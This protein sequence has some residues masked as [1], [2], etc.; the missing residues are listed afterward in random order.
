ML[1]KLLA[2]W[3]AVCF[4]ALGFASSAEAAYQPTPQTRYAP[5]NTVFAIAVTPTR[6]YIGGQFLRLTPLAGGKVISRQGIAAFDRA[7][8]DLITSFHPTF[9]SGVVRSIAVSADESTVLV[10]GAFTTVNGVSHPRLAAVS[11]A[12][13]TLIP[14]WDTT[15]NGAVRDIKVVGSS[16]YLGGAFGNVGGLARLGLTK[17]DV[18]TGTVDRTWNPGTAGG[19]P[20]A[21]TLSE[22]NLVV[23]GAFTTL[24]GAP[25][26]F[27]GSVTLDTGA[28][29]SW[30]PAS[31][32]STCTVIDVASDAATNSVLAGMAGP[33]GKAVSYDA[34]TGALRWSDSS[35]GNVQAITTDGVDVYIGGHFGPNPTNELYAANIGTGTIDPGFEPSFPGNTFPGIWALEA[36]PEALYVGGGFVG[37]NGTTQSKYAVFPLI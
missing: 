23:G 36:A 1:K 31:R 4:L 8:G 15:A 13:G 22:G 16:A 21:L 12:D 11:A 7:T 19:R 3:V 2:T 37:V 25:R 10:G 29:T 6:I 35:D 5:N 26:D 34:A 27:L 9:T 20:T 30:T 17:I 18:S 14:G 32:C 24:G 33:G 28:V